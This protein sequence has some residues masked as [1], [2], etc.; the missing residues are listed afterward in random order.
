MGSGV[1]E[2][3]PSTQTGGGGDLNMTLSSELFW[4][5]DYGLILSSDMALLMEMFRITPH[6]RSRGLGQCFGERANQRFQ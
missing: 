6:Q 4:E 3:A 1:T 2:V 5:V